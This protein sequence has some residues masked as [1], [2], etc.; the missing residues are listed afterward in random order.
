MC[1]IRPS[2]DEIR[3][4]AKRLY[5][6]GGKSDL[7]NWLKAEKAIKMRTI[8]GFIYLFLGSLL[9]V[10]TVYKL[11]NLP[12]HLLEAVKRVIDLAINYLGII[13]CIGFSMVG[14]GAGLIN[15]RNHPQCR[16]LHLLG[17]WLFIIFVV[18]AISF[19]L[20]LYKSGNVYP[21]LDIKFYSLSALIGLIGG[22]LGH[23]FYDL[24]LKVAV[25]LGK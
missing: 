15:T 11:V 10:F 17:Y 3:E 4:L 2:E 8:S 19:T 9:I 24:I 25:F 20:S 18:S 23:T 12:M 1:F 5:N 6:E 14:A 13:W 22:F 16:A 21:D 7:D